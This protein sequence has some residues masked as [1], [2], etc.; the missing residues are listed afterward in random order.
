M[1]DPLG[2][3]TTNTYD[4][5]GN[6]LSTTDAAGNTTN[7][8]YDSAGHDVDDRPLGNVTAMQYDAKAA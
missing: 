5:A 2:Y 6:L 4:G 7:Y 8:T 1:T 3:T